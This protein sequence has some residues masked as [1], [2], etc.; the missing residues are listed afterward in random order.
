MKSI[1]IK[2]SAAAALLATSAFAFAANMDCCASIECCLK[3]L[4]CCL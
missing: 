3:M 1:L 4:A 2:T